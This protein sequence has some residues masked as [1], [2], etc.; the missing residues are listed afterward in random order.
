MP[1][2]TRRFIKHWDR[3]G[4]WQTKKKWTIRFVDQIDDVSMLTEDQLGPENDDIHHSIENKT[5]LHD[6]MSTTS[7]QTY[8]IGYTPISMHSE[9]RRN[10]L[11]SPQMSVNSTQPLTMNRQCSQ[12]LSERE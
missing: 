5:G 9:M 10:N 2:V 7:S 8:K 12:T 4:A 11:N 3:H 6:T 1:H